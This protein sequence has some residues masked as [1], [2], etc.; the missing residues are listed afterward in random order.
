W[1]WFMNTKFGQWLDEMRQKITD[2]SAWKWTIDVAFPAFMEGTQAVITAVVEAA[3]EM[4]EAI[5]TG[6]Q[7]GDWGAFWSVSSEVWSRGVL[8]SVSILSV[9]KGLAAL[10]GIILA[11]L[12]AIP[13]MGIPGVIGAIT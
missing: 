1:E 11:G 10:K 12:G 9:V 2:S 5:K 4:Y 8:L 13:A 7:T 3:G 6:L